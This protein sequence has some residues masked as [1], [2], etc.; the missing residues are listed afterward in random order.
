MNKEEKIDI[1]P[2]PN[3]SKYPFI[4][5][6]NNKKLAIFLGAGVSKIIGCALWE[7][8]AKN[9]I[10]ECYEQKCINF[11]E[12][13]LLEE[14]TDYKKIIDVCKAILHN[15]GL[16]ENYYNVIEKSLEAKNE[17]QKKY[18]IYKEI[19]K[20]SA[21]FITTNLDTYLDKNL[22]KESVFKLEDLNK[23]NIYIDNIYH[24]HGSIDDPAR[25]WV[26]TPDQYIARYNKSAIFKDFLKEIYDNYTILF[27]GYGMHEFELLDFLVKDG[28]KPKIEHYLLRPSFNEEENLLKYEQEYYAKFNVKIIPFSMNANGYNQLYDVVKSWAE[29]IELESSTLA[30]DLTEIDNEINKL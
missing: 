5:A 13:K 20:L 6:I 14:S 7:E 25:D 22:K 1:S 23:D 18:D 24:I 8:L 15:Y 4:E 2:I 26:L 30:D 16:E 11:L 9:L 19:S 10:K 17:L 27:M 21:L 12:K 3:I 28:E 29:T